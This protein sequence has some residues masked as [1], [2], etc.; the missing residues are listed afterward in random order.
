MV[1]IV[2]HREHLALVAR[3]PG[4]LTV[5]DLFNRAGEREAEPSEASDGAGRASGR[6]RARWGWP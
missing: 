4:R 2:E 6:R 1:V 3:E 5:R